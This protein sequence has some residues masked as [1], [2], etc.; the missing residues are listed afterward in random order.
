MTMTNFPHKFFR[1]SVAG[2]VSTGLNLVLLYVFTQY[3][4]VWYL[5]AS[6]IAFIISV[7][8]HFLLQKMWVFIHHKVTHSV[9]RQF[10]GFTTLALLN[11]VLNSASMYLFVSI[12]GINYLISQIFIRLLLAWMNYG[13]YERMIFTKPEGPSP[14]V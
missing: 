10:G 11:L 9:G 5:T 8:T 6:T 4:G 2:L 3:L 7:G 1:F 14:E 12:I 13:L